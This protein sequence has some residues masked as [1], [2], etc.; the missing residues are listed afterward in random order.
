LLSGH[1]F[2]DYLD[3]VGISLDEFE[4]WTEDS[5]G[6]LFGYI[7]ALY[8]GGIRTVLVVWSREARQPH[9]RVYVHRNMAVWVLPATRA[10]RAA[11]WFAG[12]LSEPSGRLARYLWRASRFFLHYSATPPRALARVL[13]H[14]RCGAI[15]V[16]EY[17]HARFD[18]CVLLGRWLDLPVLATFQGGMPPRD[19]VQQ[20]IRRQIV[21]NAAGLLIGS[22]QEAVDVTR[23]YR[24]PSGIVARVP[25][26]VNQY[27][28]MPGDQAAARAA[29]SLPADVPIA[30]WNGRVEIW[31]KGLDVLVEAWR[32][33]C[34]ERPSMDVR[35]LL[36]GAGTDSA[37]LRR[38]IAAAGL[39]G[40]HW[41][42]EFVLDSNVIR[43]QLTAADVYVL[44]SRHEGFA[45]A[46]MEAMACGRPV[47][48]CDAPGVTDLLDGRDGAGGL[49]VPREDPEALATA[50]GRL[51][52]DRALAARLGEMARCRIV[53]RY[54][55]EAVGLMLASALHTAAPDRFPT[56]P[57]E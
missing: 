52:D 16:Q 31:P 50:L 10:H 48:A 24:L 36:L 27:T 51:L 6:W 57:A 7:E 56:P 32:L 4:F 19:R 26:A 14:E 9:R 39:R 49:V 54:S 40:I 35:L 21:P 13:L 46:P 25:N 29:L 44:P 20:W 47:V 5:G 33:V 8:R 42:D 23:R 41:R 28:W 15:I 55:L 30:C 22:Q 17:E 3:T 38:L 11:R 18:I 37:R 1:I 53:E 43:R 12:R 34:A 2:E 45:V